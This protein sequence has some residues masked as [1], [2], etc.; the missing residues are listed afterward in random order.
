MSATTPETASFSESGPL[1][2]VMRVPGDKSIAHRALICA[3]LASGESRVRG[4]PRGEDVARTRAALGCLGVYFDGERVVGGRE[5]LR[6]PE[7]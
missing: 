5:R 4:L 1:R 7:R 6:E 3:A 2:G